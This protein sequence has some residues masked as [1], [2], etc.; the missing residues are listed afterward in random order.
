M[1]ANN[2]A[3]EHLSQVV[4]RT[5]AGIAVDSDSEADFGEPC[6]GLRFGDGTVAWIMRD[7]EGNGPGFLDIEPGAGARRRYGLVNSGDGNNTHDLGPCRS[8]EEAAL[9]G[10][11]ALGWGL[12]VEDDTENGEVEL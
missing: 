5:V 12:T 1:S 11:A 8:R 2:A 7:A 10:L 9:A 6:H 4:G 3:A